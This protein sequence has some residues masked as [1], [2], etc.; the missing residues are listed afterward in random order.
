MDGMLYVSV[1]RNLADG[2]GT[3]WDPHFC[4]GYQSSFHE[5]P[6][7]YF[8][9]LAVFYKVLG[10]SMYVERVF[11][12]CCFALTGFFIHKL[13]RKI[14]INEPSI[15][16]NSW[17]PVLYWTVIP[18]CFWAYTNMVE[19]VVM[20]LFVVMAVYYSFIALFLAKNVILNLFLSGIFIF[21]AFFT[22][23]IQGVFPV[24]AAGAFWLTGNRYPFKKM[25]LHSFILVGVPLLVYFILVTLSADAQASFDAYFGKR[26]VGT[27]TN[28]NDTTDT[29]FFLLGRLTTHLLPIVLLSFIL[30]FVFRK[31]KAPVKHERNAQVI[32]WLL[33]LG[34]SGSLPLLITLEQRSFYL[35]T[36]MPFFALAIAVWAA[37][38]LSMAIASADPGTKKYRIFTFITALLLV[39]SVVFSAMQAGK[40][41]RDEGTLQDVYAFGKLLPRGERVTVPTRMDYEFSFKEYMIRYFYINMVKT[42][43]RYFI[44]KKDTP[45]EFIPAAYQRYPI[46]TKE[47]DLYIKK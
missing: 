16:V 46:E 40:A 28:R 34:F 20:S 17:L 36:S 38:R 11:C 10:S 29:H 47:F 23:G 5:Q 6:P 19:E 4:M 37:P 8:G 26:L 45:P 27:F 12:F 39:V 33:L 2:I 31:Y 3:F 21:L 13:W 22:K 1:S 15:A 44:C 43:E 18:I 35:V 42:D 41:K 7:L 25:L 30:R 14:F 24:I 9:L 32:K